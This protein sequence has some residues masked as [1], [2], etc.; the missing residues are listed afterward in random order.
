M[1]RATREP[2]LGHAGIRSDPVALL[3]K[4][5][6]IADNT[7]PERLRGLDPHERQRLTHRYTKARQ[8]VGL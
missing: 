2:A 8:Q 1:R 7:D 5:A 3:I 4:G 6:D